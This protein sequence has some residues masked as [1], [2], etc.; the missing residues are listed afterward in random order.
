MKFLPYLCAE[1][2]QLS[3]L[4][5]EWYDLNGRRLTGKPT[6]KGIYIHRGRRV[7]IP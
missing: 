1:Y 5:G 3:I 6:R 7:L 2:Y 4:N